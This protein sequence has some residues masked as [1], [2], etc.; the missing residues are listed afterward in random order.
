MSPQTQSEMKTFLATLR[1]IDTL[2]DDP[3]RRNSL[4]K[5]FS[6]ELVLFG[7]ETDQPYDLRDSL[8]VDV[9]MAR[10]VGA[11]TMTLPE[12]KLNQNVVERLDSEGFTINGIVWVGD[13]PST[14]TVIGKHFVIEI[15]NPKSD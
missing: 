10:F 2:L 13:L 11:K 5:D 3:N 1:R 4:K 15:R 12:G 8:R 14:W 7:L 9:G 6:S